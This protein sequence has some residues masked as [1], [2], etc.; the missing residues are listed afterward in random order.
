MSILFPI[1]PSPLCSMDLRS[2]CTRIP[3]ILVAGSIV[4]FT[5]CTACCRYVASHSWRGVLC[6][7]LLPWQPNTFSTKL[8]LKAIFSVLME[9]K[10]HLCC[11]GLSL[12][13]LKDMVFD[14]ANN[15]AASLK[16]VFIQ[17]PFGQET[18]QQPG[19]TYEQLFPCSFPLALLD[20]PLLELMWVVSSRTQSPTFLCAGIK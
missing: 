10:D 3:D 12:R 11:P 20:Y 6:G 8:L 18:T 17:E 5:I 9:C 14:L 4:T 1:P 2:L 19:T 13:G 7:M 15:I 16:F